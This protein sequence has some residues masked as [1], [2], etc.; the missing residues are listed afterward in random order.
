MQRAVAFLEKSVPK[1]ESPYYL[2]IT[3][4]ALALV[5]SSAKY[6]ANQKLIKKATY[7]PG[8]YLFI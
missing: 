7:N 3:T 8:E 1:I 5:N 2:A 6:E 4:Y